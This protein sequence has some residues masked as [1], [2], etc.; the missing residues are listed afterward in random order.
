[1]ASAGVDY[2]VT[3]GVQGPFSLAQGQTAASLWGR[4]QEHDVP[5]WLTPVPGLDGHP[6]AVYRVRR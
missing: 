5:D 6:F 4:L 1:L 2:V 3:C